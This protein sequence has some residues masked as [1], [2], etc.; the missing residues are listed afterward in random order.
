MMGKLLSAIFQVLIRIFLK[1]V[2]FY[3]LNEAQELKYGCN[4]PSFAG[5]SS[6]DLSKIQPILPFWW[7]SIVCLPV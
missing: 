7:S 3:R 5:L 2:S 6:L 4:M 1:T